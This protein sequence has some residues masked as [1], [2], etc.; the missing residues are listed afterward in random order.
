MKITAVCLEMNDSSLL[1]KIAI[2][3]HEK[4]G[5]EALLLTSDLR[6]GKSNP[7]LRHF[8]SGEERLYEFYA[9]AQESHILKTMFLS[10]FGS[11]PQTGSLDIHSDIIAG[12]I[13]LG[14]VYGIVS[15]AAAQFEH[16]RVVIP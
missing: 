16:Y 14:K 9:G 2:A 13:A 10:I 8:F 12:R 4:R 5:R 15:L 6:V 11:F 1:K 3:V 7:Y